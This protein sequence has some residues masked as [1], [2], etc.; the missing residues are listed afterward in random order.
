MLMGVAVMALLATEL[1][2]EKQALRA[3]RGNELARTISGKQV[4]THAS[5]PESRRLQRSEHFYKDG[6]Y[7][8]EFH[9][10]ESLGR[11]RIEG[12]A[13][14]VMIGRQAGPWRHCR[15]AIVDAQGR[16]WFVRSLEPANFVQVIVSDI[17]K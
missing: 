15:I 2:P 16:M 1:Q 11:Y 4:Q 3:L 10:R 8:G 5:T 14:C 6:R 12:D 17:P 9:G 7:R 13:V